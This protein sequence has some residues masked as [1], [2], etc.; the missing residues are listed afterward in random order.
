MDPNKPPA[1]YKLLQ[2]REP[3]M[4][5]MVSLSISLYLFI[6][7]LKSKEFVYIYMIQTYLQKN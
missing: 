1:V 7:F 5:K 3:F 2:S 6:L 4:K